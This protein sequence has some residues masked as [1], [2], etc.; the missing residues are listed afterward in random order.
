MNRSVNLW[1]FFGMQAPMTLN[2]RPISLYREET[3]YLYRLP[4]WLWQEL[5]AEEIS[6][7]SVEIW[8]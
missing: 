8:H 4:G 7:K 3:F 6:E 5:D 2:A 1:S